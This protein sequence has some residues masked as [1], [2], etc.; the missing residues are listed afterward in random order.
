MFI[1]RKSSFKGIIAAILITTLT[2]SSSL[3]VYAETT[4]E[5]E[6]DSYCSVTAEDYV[7]KAVMSLEFVADMSLY[8]EANYYDI[9][10]HTD[11]VKM[12]NYVTEGT[13]CD[14]YSRNGLRVYT[15]CYGDFEADGYDG[16]SLHQQLEVWHD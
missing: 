11:T 10:D 1:L 16:E 15:Y 13:Y 2:V 12:S 14:V 5:P 8:A 9:Y 3:C 6:E 7:A 4:E